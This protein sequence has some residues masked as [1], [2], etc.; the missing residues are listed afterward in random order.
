[1]RLP[2]SP[3]T[4]AAVVLAITGAAGCAKIDAQLTEFTVRPIRVRVEGVLAGIAA[5]GGTTGDK[6]NMAMYLWDG[7]QRRAEGTSPEGIYDRF[8]RWC[9]E[10]NINR[11]LSSYEIL[12][13]DVQKSPPP[14]TALV[15]VRIEGISYRMRVVE[16]QRIAWVD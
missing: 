10:K 15:S 7:G 3:L 9:Q 4:I 5:E 16:G 13:I 6:L 11:R 12:A 1:M 8:T 14:A 2:G